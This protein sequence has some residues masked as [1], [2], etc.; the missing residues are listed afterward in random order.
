MDG[1]LRFDDA[2]SA[3]LFLNESS[4]EANSLMT[5]PFPLSRFSLH[6]KTTTKNHQTNNELLLFVCKIK[7]YLFAC[8]RVY[9]ILRTFVPGPKHPLANKL[10]DM[11]W[12]ISRYHQ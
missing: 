8:W 12:D 10:F 9:G 3:A 4:I 6:N 1:V 2:V 11:F 5:L 7:L